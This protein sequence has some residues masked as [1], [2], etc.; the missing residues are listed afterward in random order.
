MRRILP[1]LALACAAANAARADDPRA[2][3]EA[4]RARLAAKG[5][6][7]ALL[8]TRRLR[9][10]VGAGEPQGSVVLRTDAVEHAGRTI[11]RLSDRFVLDLGR[12]GSARLRVE[13]DATLDL[14]PLRVL[15]ESEESRGEGLRSRQLVVLEPDPSGR[16]WIRSV[17]HG[18]G[19]AE[20]SRAELPAGALVLTPP[21]GLGE[22]LARLAPDALGA[23]YKLP[24]YDLETGLST[25]WRLGVEDLVAVPSRAGPPLR[26]LRLVRREG[27][28]RLE[29]WRERAPGGAPL[30]VARRGASRLVL[31]APTTGGPDEAPSGGPSACVL[32][33]LHALA[34]RDRTVVE[35]V[36]DFDALYRAAGGDPSATQRRAHFVAALLEGLFDPAWIEDHG[37]AL[38]GAAAG[39]GDL[40]EEPAS[41]G[42][43]RVRVGGADGPAFL[44][45]PSPQGW[46]IVD[47]PR[48]KR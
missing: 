46:R 13:A 6:V 9:A 29:L 7:R 38:A 45:A 43:C 32:A 40:T 5:P 8:E 34:R 35:R 25:V 31:L 37:L 16:G 30:R 23:R 48:P 17:T 22:R 39:P 3:G 18:Y 20:R 15:L 11:Y 41:S 42:C 27:A 44:L 33:F 1:A 14:R 4:L 36:L 12:L 21:L 28:A 24:A 19:E 10:F 26:A 47:F 2:A